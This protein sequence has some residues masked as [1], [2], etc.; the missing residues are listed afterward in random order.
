MRP[1]ITYHFDEEREMIYFSNGYQSLVANGGLFL[2]YI[3]GE[4]RFFHED[5]VEL[6][7]QT[8]ILFQH[9]PKDI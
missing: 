1:I 5:M 4:K 3:D 6:E 9:L 8:G 7:E 2:W